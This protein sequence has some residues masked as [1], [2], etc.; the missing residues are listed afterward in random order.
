D[1][2]RRRQPDI[3]KAKTLLGWEPSVPLQDGLKRTVEDFRDRL[4]SG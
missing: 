2:P 4:A 1:D 3:T